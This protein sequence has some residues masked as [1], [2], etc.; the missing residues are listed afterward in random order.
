MKQQVTIYTDGSYIPMT[1]VGGWAAIIETGDTTTTISGRVPGPTTN[2]RME[3]TA[4]L[5]ALKTL[6]YSSTVTIYSDSQ[7]SINALST[8]VHGWQKNNWMTRATKYSKS[9]KV[10]NVELLKEILHYMKLHKV[11]FIWVKGH[12]GHKENEL[13]DKLC[14]EEAIG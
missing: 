7:Y 12:N 14:R 1:Q 11:K 5:E 9:E 10:K 4:I 8:W 2:N 6:Q 13:V 3:L